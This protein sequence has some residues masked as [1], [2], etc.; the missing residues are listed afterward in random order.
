MKRISFNKFKKSCHHK[1]V[2]YVW[3]K[4][5]G[6]LKSFDSDKFYINK[7]DKMYCMPS[8]L[9]GEEAE[10]FKHPDE[11]YYCVVGDFGRLEVKTYM[12]AVD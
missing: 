7:K 10:F 5:D 12:E 2:L 1:K 8:F 6:G 4:K 3:F 9:I 11:G